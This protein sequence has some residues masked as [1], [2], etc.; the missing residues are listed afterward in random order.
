[1]RILASWDHGPTSCP[2]A[3]YEGI[4]VSQDGDTH[5]IFGRLLSLGCELLQYSGCD[6]AELLPAQSML[7]ARSTAVASLP[8]EAVLG[9]DAKLPSAERGDKRESS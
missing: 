6:S 8:C 2:L 7:V 9:H 4:F 5:I 3:R 1:M